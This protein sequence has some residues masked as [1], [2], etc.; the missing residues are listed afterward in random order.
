MEVTVGPHHDQ[1]GRCMY[2]RTQT[3]SSIDNR[4][5]V[6]KGHIKH[7]YWARKMWLVCPVCYPKLVQYL[8]RTHSIDLTINP[9]GNPDP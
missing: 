1:V 2:C 3:D 5:A 7:G 9:A 8:K 6:P 4:E